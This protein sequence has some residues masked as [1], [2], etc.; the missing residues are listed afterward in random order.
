MRKASPLQPAFALGLALALCPGVGHGQNLPDAPAPPP[1]G[2]Q[3]ET[4]PSHVPVPATRLPNVEALNQRQWSGVVEPGEKIPPLTDRE[5]LLFSLHEETRVATTLIPILS[6][7]FYGNLTNSDPKYG[8]NADSFG[9]RVGAS[10]LHQATSRLISDSF[11]PILLHEDPRYY[12]Q[13]YG[14]YGS[15]T[16]HALRRIFISQK[17]SGGQT[18]N[19]SDVLG[20]GMSAALTQAYYPDRSVS[21]AVVFRSWGVSLAALG[22]G[23]MFEEFW[24]DVKRKLFHKSR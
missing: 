11:L 21:A 3:P 20:R 16:D 12:R 13:A 14:S 22:G 17:D 5:K 15:R 9:E 7:G 2:Q 24:P 10:A 23:N 8:T 1:L 19:F 18:F 4:P 6:S